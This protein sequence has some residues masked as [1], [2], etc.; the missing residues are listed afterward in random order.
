MNKRELLAE[1]DPEML[2]ADGWDEH[3]L[4]TAFS[5]GRKQLVVYDGDGIIN[6]L[7]T[8][9]GLSF[10][11]AQEYFAFNIEG[12]WVGQR[13]PVFVRGLDLPEFEEIGGTDAE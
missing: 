12:A 2:C 4:G 8:R 3:I 13:T 5:P 1:M 10:E 7:I 6:T 11:E 9:D